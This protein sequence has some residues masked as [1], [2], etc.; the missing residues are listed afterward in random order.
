MGRVAI[1][2]RVLW[3]YLRIGAPLERCEAIVAKCAKGSIPIPTLILT[4]Y[5]LMPKAR[6]SWHRADF[7]QRGDSGPLRYGYCATI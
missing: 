6:V 4:D 3:D 2:G 5:A 7:A 1:L